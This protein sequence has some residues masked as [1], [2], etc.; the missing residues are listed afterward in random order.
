MSRSVVGGETNSKAKTLPAAYTQL[1]R[2]GLEQSRIAA[3]QTV[4]LDITQ[5]FGIA[6]VPELFKGMSE[7]PAYL[8]T[9]WELFKED[10]CIDQLDY[11]TKQIIAL[12]ISTDAA[13]RYCITAYPHSFR[14]SVLD[15][16]LCDK[17]VLTIRFFKAFDRYLSG[18]T[19]SYIPDPPAFVSGCLRDEY[20]GFKETIPAHVVP[21]GENLRFTDV[22]LGGLLLIIF[23][24]LPIAITIYLFV[25]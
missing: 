22:L 7:K 21:S 14:L 9:A 2:T 5:T 6:F 17:I 1:E 19:L 12:A 24:L 3:T 11:K 25:T 4:F 8:A 15:E 13:G 18:V 23:L 10:L 16:A 20:E